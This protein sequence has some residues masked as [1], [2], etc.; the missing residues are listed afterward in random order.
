[1]PGRRL[2]AACQA[3]WLTIASGDR[4]MVSRCVF[5]SRSQTS[6]RKLSSAVSTI[7]GRALSQPRENPFETA[8]RDKASSRSSL[9]FLAKTVSKATTTSPPAAAMACWAVNSK[10]DIASPIGAFWRFPMAFFL[11][12]YIRNKEHIPVRS[13][14]IDSHVLILF[15]DG[16]LVTGD[17][18]FLS[19]GVDYT[20]IDLGHK[21]STGNNVFDNGSLGA[22]PETYR[23]DAKVDAV[24]ARLTYKFG[25]G[26]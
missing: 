10:S 24:M 19:L 8:A 26:Q 5:S 17:E 14:G 22:N 9:A 18:L 21:T 13:R 20:H 11:L 6:I 3:A 15:T 23:T 25:M 16:K 4:Q 1:M 2:M 12:R 7:Y